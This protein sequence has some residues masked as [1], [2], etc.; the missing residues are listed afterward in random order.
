MKFKY[1]GDIFYYN[2]NISYKFF[3]FNKKL[4]FNLEIT[5][6]K[7]HLKYLIIIEK[8]NSSLQYVLNLQT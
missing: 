4:L 8:K 1:F 7:I 6:Y 5:I 2:K 3:Q